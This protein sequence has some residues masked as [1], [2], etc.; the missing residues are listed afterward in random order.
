[1]GQKYNTEKSRRQEQEAG[2]QEAGAGGRSRRQ[3]HRRQEQEAG[4]GA[5][6]R[7]QEQQ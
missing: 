2:A 3:E 4:A 7:R 1:M 6:S 5:R